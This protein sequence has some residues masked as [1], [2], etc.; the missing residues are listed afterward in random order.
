MQQV[1][2]GHPKN[3]VSR[4]FK[5]VSVGYGGY[6]LLKSS[7][8]KRA[9]LLKAYFAIFVYMETEAIHIEMDRSLSSDAL[10]NDSKRIITRKGNPSVILSDNGTHFLGARNQ[11][12]E[13]HEFLSQKDTYKSIQ[14]CSQNFIEFNFLLPRLY[15]KKFELNSRT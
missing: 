15:G 7:H 12:K 6:F 5:K 1:M 13:L 8:L 4:S 3:Q 9:P 14:D 2:A 10:F 11:L